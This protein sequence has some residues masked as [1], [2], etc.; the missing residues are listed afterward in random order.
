MLRRSSREN[1]A[2]AA[3]PREQDG[4]RDR[5]HHEKNGAPSG[6]LGEQIGCAAWTKGRLRTLTAKC[7]SQIGRLALL[8]KYYADQEQT[9]DDMKNNQEINHRD[10]FE[11][12]ENW[13]VAL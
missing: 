3:G 9:D 6:E 8:Q 7:S 4:E 13:D 5:N 1:G 10:C 11:T 2:V 12:S